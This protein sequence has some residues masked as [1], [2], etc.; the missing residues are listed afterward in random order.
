MDVTHHLKVKSL[1]LEKEKFTNKAPN[2]Q[3][4][5]SWTAKNAYVYLNFFKQNHA[6]DGMKD[7]GLAIG[8]LYLP[9]YTDYPQATNENIKMVFLTIN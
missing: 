1:P 8:L 9:G 4:S 3:P 2:G 5:K 6:V 7:K